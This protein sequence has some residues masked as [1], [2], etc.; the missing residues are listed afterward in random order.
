[1]FFKSI[2]SVL[3]SLGPIPNNQVKPHGWTSSDI[4]GMFYSLKMDCYC[5]FSLRKRFTRDV[6]PPRYWL[7][8]SRDPFWFGDY[9][10]NRSHTRIKYM[11][12]TVSEKVCFCLF[13]VSLKVG[14]QFY[15]H[16]RFD[17]QG[18]YWSYEHS[19]SVVMTMKILGHRLLQQSNTIKQKKQVNT[20][21]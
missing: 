15:A 11:A 16:V 18:F 9:I 8:S 14:L 2:W 10:L 4:F 7:I 20:K 1:M 19:Y 13:E 17:V 6:K 5:S 21:R 12:F 3:Q